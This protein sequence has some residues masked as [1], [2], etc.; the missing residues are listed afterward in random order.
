MGWTFDIAA[1]A[2]QQQGVKFDE[3]HAL[4]DGA[5]V[6]A[7]LYLDVSTR[8]RPWWQTKQ[9]KP[10]GALHCT[11][12]SYACERAWSC[13]AACLHRSTSLWGTPPDSPQGLRMT[14]GQARGH[15]SPNRLEECVANAKALLH[16]RLEVLGGRVGEGGGR[17]GFAVR[18]R[19]GG[20]G[21]GVGGGVEGPRSVGG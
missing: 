12:C 11:A 15:C 3:E 1:T 7:N 16:S 9:G 20:G 2:C 17:G 6:M 10:R 14:E 18:A 19:P 8:S 4:Y 5:L 13:R 21:G